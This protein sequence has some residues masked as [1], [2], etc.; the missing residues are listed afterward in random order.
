MRFHVKLAIIT[1]SVLTPAVSELQFAILYA[2]GTVTPKVMKLCVIGEAGAGKTTLLEALKGGWFQSWF[3]WERQSDDPTCEL[4]RTVGIN[5]MTVTIPGV[6][7]FALFDYA[8]QKQFHK[9]HGLFFS[10]FNSF[11]ILLI[12]LLTGE[13]RRPCTFEELIH[14]AQYWLS[15]LRASLGVEFIPTVMIAASRADSCPDGQV[16]LQQVVSHMRDVFKGK[17][18][19][20]EECFLLDYRKSWSP[21]MQQL[22]ELLKRVRDEYMQVRSLS[23]IKC[24]MNLI[25]WGTQAKTRYRYTM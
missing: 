17:I 15:F 14:V 4:E 11:F 18:Q 24:M 16:L 21:G 20:R 3:T 7:R 19:I 6:G 2:A 25:A 13:E 1:T 12:S 10:A 9:T 8:G 22:R 5:V 23:P